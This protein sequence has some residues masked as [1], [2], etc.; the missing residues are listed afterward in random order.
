M[1]NNRNTSIILVIIKYIHLV[2]LSYT[3]SSQLMARSMHS[4]TDTCVGLS[5]AIISY[6]D[7]STVTI[8]GM[9]ISLSFCARSPCESNCSNA[10]ERLNMSTK[11]DKV[12]KYKNNS[13]LFRTVLF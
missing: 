5:A 10:V 7:V 4:G 8:S 13:Y 6:S 1:N 12:R 2:Y 3:L 9:S 11:N